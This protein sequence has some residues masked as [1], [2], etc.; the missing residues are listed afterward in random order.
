LLICTD[1]FV[2]VASEDSDSIDSF[3]SY[4][5]GKSALDSSVTI[6]DATLATS[7]A[8]GYFHPITISGRQF[9]DGG[10]NA[11]NPINKVRS[12]AANIYHLDE[13]ELRNRVTCLIS[14]GTGKA[15]MRAMEGETLTRPDGMQA[16]AEDMARNFA[17]GW[18]IDKEGNRIDANSYFR[19]NVD[20]GLQ[21]VELHEYTKINL[22]EYATTEYLEQVE[23]RV[24]MDEIVSKLGE[25][26]RSRE[27]VSEYR[28]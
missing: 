19:L 9:G 20:A 10:I 11:N 7:A 25:R 1:R 6:V 5:S 8:T 2:R 14:I 24:A 16:A 3:R 18:A 4:T 22:I 26:L 21:D 13:G 17:S 15:H 27:L 28:Q 12:E 23:V